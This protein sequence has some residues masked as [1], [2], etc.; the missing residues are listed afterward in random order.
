MFFAV[1]TR[2]VIHW[3]FVPALSFTNHIICLLFFVT[4]WELRRRMG[5]AIGG[6]VWMVHNHCQ[7]VTLCQYKLHVV[8]LAGDILTS[9]SPNSDPGLG[10][11]TVAWHPS[12]NFLAVG[13]WDDKVIISL[14]AYTNTSYPTHHKI[15]ILDNLSWSNVATLEIS[16]RIPS[17]V[18]SLKAKIRS[19]F[20]S[21]ISMPDRMA[22]AF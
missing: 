16:T 6:T 10:I 4:Y 3:S 7:Y 17:S 1:S 5:R 19:S 2:L 9:F 22:R 12:G 11:R 8:T 21:L 18:V 20:I 14:C 15:H 13:G